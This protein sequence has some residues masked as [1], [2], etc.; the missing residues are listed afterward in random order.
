MAVNRIGN[1]AG[2]KDGITDRDVFAD[3]KGFV[4]DETIAYGQAVAGDEDDVTAASGQDA[5]IAEA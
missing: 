1:S 4:F 5:L 3:T 2:A